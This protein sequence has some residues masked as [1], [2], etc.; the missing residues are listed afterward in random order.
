MK[1]TL[2]A[3]AIAAVTL[4]ANTFAMDPTTE[5]AER[6]DAMPTFYGNIQ[7]AFTA[8][9]NGDNWDE[10][11]FDNGSTLGVKHSH[12]ISPGLEGFLKAEFEFDADD[13][14]ASSGLS[15]LDEAYIGLKG[16][17]GK[18]W[19]GTDDSAYENVDVINHNEAI[20]IAG[21]LAG[22]HE[23]DTL[24]YKTP[25]IAGGLAV[26]LTFEMESSAKHDGAISIEYAMDGITLIGAYALA[27]EGD[28]AYGLAVT[29]ELGDIT[30]A[31]QFENE[32]DINL[33]GVNAVFVMGDNQ[34][35]A[36]VAYA[37]DDTDE[38]LGISGQAL[39]NLSDN[40]YVYVEGYYEDVDSRKDAETSL[41]L[42][43]TYSF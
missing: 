24:Q 3:S 12:E 34:F 35:A 7:L 15:K 2:I 41:A 10:D 31:A 9:D 20:G 42:G 30:V 33:Y 25:E 28:D 22:V 37:D 16:D 21:D 4:S 19:F 43:A 40:M 17:F 14:K 23:G 32:D 39:H 11:F 26:Q 29:A 38:V 13:K 8:T 6:L 18:V 27:D 36:G 5:L 1:K